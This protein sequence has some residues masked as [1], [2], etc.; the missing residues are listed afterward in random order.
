MKYIFTLPFPVQWVLKRELGE[1]YLSIGVAATALQIFES[2]EMW[3]NIITCY[4]L[5]NKKEQAEQ[6][7]RKRLEIEPSPQLWCVLGDL[8]NKEEYY[9]KS[10]EFSNHHYA[11][12]KRSLARL[13]LSQKQVFFKKRKN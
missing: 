13:Y 7:V 3:D 11:R 10:W 9:E 12:A 4:Q 5:L 6:I 2:L 1:K 8:T